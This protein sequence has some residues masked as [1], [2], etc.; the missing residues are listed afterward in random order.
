M[1][2][3]RLSPYNIEDDLIRVDL[4]R[5][6][7]KGSDEWPLYTIQPDEILSPD[8]VSYRAYGTDELKWV[9]LVA[10]GLDDPREALEAGS[11]I[12]LPPIVWI[13]EKIKEYAGDIYEG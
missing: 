5:E 10:A 7:R 9:V 8:L 6:I 4:Y 2:I 3:S 11:T 13:R 12:K 1:T